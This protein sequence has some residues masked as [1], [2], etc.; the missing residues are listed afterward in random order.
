LHPALAPLRSLFDNDR[1]L[2]IVANVGPLLS[3]TTKTQYAQP[4]HPKPASLYSHN[5]QQNTWQAFAPEGAT[6]GWGG[7]MADMLVSNNQQAT[8]TA[9]SAAGNA[10]WLSGYTVRQY[11][12]ANS[13]AIRMGARANGMVFESPAVTAAM[14]RIARRSRTHVFEYDLASVAG[15]SIDAEA[16]LRNAL[17]PESDAAFSGDLNV[18]DPVP[19][20]GSHFVNPLA[21]QLRM[22]ARMIQAARNGSVGVKRQVFFV[23]L[24]GFDTHDRQNVTHARLLAQLAHGMAWFDNALGAMGARSNVTTFTASD[25]GR[26]FTSNG[27]GTDHGWGGHHFVMGGSV[28]GGDIFGTF[29]VLGAKNANN[30]GFDSSPDQLQNGVLLPSLSVDQYGATLARWFGV[31]DGSLGDVFPR[32]GAFAQRDIGFMA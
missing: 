10:V 16:A 20:N 4:Q 8:F 25:F 13:G 26:S 22:V 15:R 1:R 30:S 21:Q 29:P 9:M 27:D 28:R 18:A 2:A 7:R 5:D 17:P 24:S 23:S 31:G 11:Q 19:T 14:E 32:I 6:V 12:V 3:P